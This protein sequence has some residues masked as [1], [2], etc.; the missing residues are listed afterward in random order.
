MSIAELQKQN[1]ELE[2]RIQRM[3]AALKLVES[4]V[5]SELEPVDVDLSDLLSDEI[6]YG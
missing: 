1:E 5:V 2:G 3:E 6:N 4:L